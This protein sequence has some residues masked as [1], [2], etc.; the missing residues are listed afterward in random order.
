MLSDGNEP[1]DFSQPAT[2]TSLAA[3]EILLCTKTPQV[4]SSNSMD[5]ILCI[6]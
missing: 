3:E 5:N 2:T 6:Q 1:I 4:T